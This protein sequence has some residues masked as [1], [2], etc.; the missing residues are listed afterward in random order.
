MPITRWAICGIRLAGE[1]PTRAASSSSFGYTAIA[2]I[3]PTIATLEMFLAPSTAKCWGLNRF[4]SPEAGL[5][6][7]KSGLIAPGIGLMPTCPAEAA[8]PASRHTPITGATASATCWPTSMNSVPTPFWVTTLSGSWAS[9]RTCNIASW[10]CS[11]IRCPT[12]LSVSSEAS[13]TAALLTSCER[14]TWP[15]LRASSRFLGVAFSVLLSATA[16]RHLQ[17]V[18]RLRDRLLEL[19]D[20]EARDERERR[21]DQ[22]QA[23]QHLGREADR[24]DVHLRDDLRDDAERGV[25]DRHRDQDG[26]GDHH[27]GHH[28]AREHELGAVDHRA[29]RRHLQQRHGVVGAADAL[30]DPRGAVDGNEHHHAEERV[31]LGQ[32]RGLVAGHGI[33]R[34]AEREADQRV[35]Q[36]AR[37][38]QRG[39]HRTQRIGE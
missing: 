6:L 3:V 35:Q 33:D 1:V 8:T 29:D 24:E 21:A 19:V 15:F 28:H 32:H 7:R 25:D 38:L 12:A 2:A 18:Q 31:H 16:L 17:E 20:D 9:W 30:D 5:S 13:R 36:A 39:E 14:A 11:T 4:L 27:A 26:R 34:R 22:R 37:H 23:D 10:H